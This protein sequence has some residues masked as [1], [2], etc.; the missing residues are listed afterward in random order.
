M[1]LNSHNIRP[2]INNRVKTPHLVIIEFMLAELREPGSSGEI[3]SMSLSSNYVYLEDLHYKKIR[4]DLKNSEAI[5]SHMNYMSEKVEELKRMYVLSSPL[6]PQ[7]KKLIALIFRNNFD[8]VIVVVHTHSDDSTGDLF[9]TSKGGVGETTLSD[10]I[11]S[12][13]FSFQHA[14]VS[15]S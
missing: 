1:A 14:L 12:V 7:V 9:Y 4:F 8:H 10:G 11:E 3:L 5:Q 15:R 13:G 6:C 2:G